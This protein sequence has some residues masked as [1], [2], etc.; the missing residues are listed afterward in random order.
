[1]TTL[2]QS[3]E[4]FKLESGQ[5]LNGIQITYS[6]Y[7][8]KN[9]ER[10]IW[11]C[12][13]L[14]GS[15]E[16]LTWWA[17]LVGDGKPFDPRVDRIICANVLG[18]CY[19]TTGAQDL[20]RPLDFPSITVKDMVH[21]HEL[22][23]EHLQLKKID[24]LIGASLGGQQALEWAIINPTLIK[25]LILIAT[26]AVHSSFGRAF[27]E[28]QRLA[29]LADQ[30]FGKKDGGKA[31]LVAARA[32]AMLSYRS[33]TDFELKQSETELKSDGFKSASYVR[34]QGEKFIARFNAYAYWYLSKAMDSHDILRGRSS[35]YQ[36][37]LKLVKASTLVIGIDS[38]GLFPVSEQKF[39]AEN[40]PDATFGLIES[41]HGHDSFLIDYEKL[42]QL[43]KDFVEQK[44]KVY[45]P[46]VLKRK[47]NYSYS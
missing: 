8:S 46:T 26:N 37:I 27:N 15:S 29:L 39:L 21:A 18:S 34:Y 30:S 19:G 9:S 31:G 41:P 3:K 12:H 43:I 44:K 23:A 20:E 40:I 36:D 6:D 28:A 1:M 7:G 4:E 14:S 16:V 22:L 45:E 24:V 38:D 10:V 32:I 17:G 13:A 2:Y 35:S 11:V 33:Y 25:Q 5:S 47:V 42:N